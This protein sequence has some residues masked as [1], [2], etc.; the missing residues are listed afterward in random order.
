M[1]IEINLKYCS[2][3][4]EDFPKPIIITHP[5]DQFALRGANVSMKCAAASTSTSVAI[6][7]RKDNILVPEQHVK[8]TGMHK[9]DI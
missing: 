2:F 5:E 1:L 6:E 9:S 4:T 7:W 8:N 3:I